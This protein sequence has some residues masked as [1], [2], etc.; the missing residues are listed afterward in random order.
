MKYRFITEDE[1]KTIRSARNV[2]ENIAKKYCRLRKK[3]R[4]MQFGEEE[5]HYR[6]FNELRNLKVDVGIEDCGDY[7]EEIQLSLSSREHILKF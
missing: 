2:L 6:M 5:A 3:G 7:S 4:C 1:E